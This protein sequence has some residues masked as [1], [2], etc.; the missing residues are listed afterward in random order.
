MLNSGK[1]IAIYGGSGCEGA[2]DAIVALEIPTGQPIVY[3]LGDDL[4]VQDRYYLSER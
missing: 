2:H 3:E 1:K 4:S